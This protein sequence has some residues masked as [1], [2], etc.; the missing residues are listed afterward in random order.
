I[1]AAKAGKIKTASPMVYILLMLLVNLPALSHPVLLIL[2][3]WIAV[4]TLYSGYEY[5]RDY[6]KALLEDA[7]RKEEHS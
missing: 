4:I 2:T 7:G 6:G 1:A 3:L 5:F